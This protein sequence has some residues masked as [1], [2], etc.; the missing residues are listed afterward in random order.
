[1][2]GNKDTFKHSDLSGD[3]GRYI[4][5]AISVSKWKLL[6]SPGEVLVTKPSLPHKLGTVWEI[7][8]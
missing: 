3:R 1:M 4:Y 6:A 7:T 2:S 5:S 8:P